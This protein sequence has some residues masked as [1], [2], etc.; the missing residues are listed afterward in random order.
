MSARQFT[1]REA[2]GRVGAAVAG[3]RGASSEGQAARGRGAGSDQPALARL[4]PR[5]DLVSTLEFED[6]ARKTL[7]AS[8]F[9]EIAGSH[10]AGFDRITLRPRMC[11]PVLDMNLSQSL[12]GETH[13][14]PIA[15]APIENQRRF[16]P[17]AEL[18]TVKGATAARAAVVV[19][20]GSSVALAEL[21]AATKTPPWYQVFASDPAASAKLRLA[22][23]AGCR[24]G[25]VTVG[26]STSAA[27]GPAAVTAADWTVVGALVRSANVPVVVKGITTPAAATTAIAR[28]AQGVIVS[29][30]T[31]S[32][33]ASAESPILTL[34]AIVDAVGGKVPVLV[35]GSFRR[36]SDILK[37]LAF[38]ARA[39]LVG[40]PV[41]WGL[42][43]YG[44]D[45][46]QSVIEMLQTELARYMGMCGKTRLAVLDRTVVQV[47]RH[48]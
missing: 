37:A 48:A 4:S 25:C 7:A 6:E 13:F 1:R 20:S 14:A 5:G 8:A 16:H 38:G 11:V 40:R 2:L 24:V 9:K 15:V 26:A 21:V 29:T 45:G 18:A 33:A 31:G 41:M 17:D 28:G 3:Q 39:V 32:T 34:P 43:A 44:A 12:F 42:A 35:D 47:H 27:G 30:Y 10:R 23:D 19:S 46:V 22:V 36:G